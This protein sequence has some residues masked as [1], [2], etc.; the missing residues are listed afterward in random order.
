[1]INA[2]RSDGAPPQVA[3]RSGLL[4]AGVLY[5]DSAVAEL[6]AAGTISQIS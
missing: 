1:M 4:A 2:Q 6:P 3:Q 5:I